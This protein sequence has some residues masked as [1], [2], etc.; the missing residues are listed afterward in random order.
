MMRH[1]TPKY[2]VVIAGA[3]LFL[4]SACLGPGKSN[5]PRYYTLNSLL[6]AAA[7]PA[8]LA[9]LHD[10]VIGVG[11]VRIPAQLDR[12]QIII[13]S[14]KNEI[15]FS[16]SAEWAEPLQNAIPRVLAE[17]LSV[18]LSTENLA[19]FP[20]LKPTSMDYQVTLDIIEFSG[21]PGADVQLRAWWTIFGEN[22]RTELLKKFADLT[23]PVGGDDMAALVRAQS[24]TLEAFS[25]QIAEVVISLSGKNR[26]G[27]GK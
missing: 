4:L 21:A 1:I 23:E 25:R 13:R 26:S 27:A 17:N 16:Q 12:S 8:P 18:L 10:I 5:P 9:D 2:A 22:G 24:R 11:P 14:A 15:R 7:R 3:W 20:W 6:G 19:I